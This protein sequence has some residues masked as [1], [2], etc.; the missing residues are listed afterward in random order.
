MVFLKT[1][2]DRKKRLPE[3]HGIRS[4]NLRPFI[5]DGLLTA[6]VSLHRGAPD[7]CPCCG[8]KF[9]SS[10]IFTGFGYYICRCNHIV[11]M[12]AGEGIDK[13]YSLKKALALF[14]E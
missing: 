1:A 6:S 14:T 10:E 9:H 11:A 12:Y 13:S 8:I 5:H 7:Y 4:R 2:V 3:K